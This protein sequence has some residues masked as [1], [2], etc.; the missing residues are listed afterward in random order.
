MNRR[1]TKYEQVLEYIR[2]RIISGEYATGERLPSDGQLVRL[3]STSRPTVAKAMH[4][5]EKE[6]YLE[7]RTGSGS[8]VK[9][10]SEA[11]P[12]I[13]GVLIPE[14]GKAELFEPIY[15]EIAT[16]CQKHHL[17]LLR[18]EWSGANL[19]DA[20][21]E[22]QAYELCKNYIEK[23]VT[24]VFFAPVEFS[25]HMKQVNREIAH[26][27]DSA[28]ISIVLL[29]RDLER[30]PKRSQYDLVGVDNFHI[31]WMQANHFIQ[32]GDKR[33]AYVSR[34]SSAPTIDLRIA[35]YLH[36]LNREG[37]S[38]DPPMIFDGPPD[39]EEFVQQI[40]DAAPTAIVCSNDTTALL[41]LKGLQNAGIDVPREIKDHLLHQT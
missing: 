38:M 32:Q 36:A 33:I 25:E 31:G 37:N 15:R 20:E 18:T 13:I 30:M 22:R 40:K 27:L 19:N 6:G 29:D 5:L 23:G 17:S 39:S 35:G 21:R 26:R 12:S 4:D 34:E 10:Q 2:D 11:Q 28:G 16:Q 1:T 24:G 8:F 41:M 7:R 14:I 3:F 9:V